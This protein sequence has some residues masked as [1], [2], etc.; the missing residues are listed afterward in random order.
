MRYI[1]VSP[2]GH[3]AFN[4]KTFKSSA[5]AEKFAKNEVPK[6][7]LMLG[8]YVM[9]VVKTSR[10]TYVAMPSFATIIGLDR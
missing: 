4:G 10:K 2:V 6:G 7:L 1:V 9:P 8:Y 5:K 3:Q